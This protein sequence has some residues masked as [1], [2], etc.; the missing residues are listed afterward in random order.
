MPGLPGVA[1]AAS[2]FSDS[3]TWLL[4]E[5]PL[6]A[7]AETVRATWLVTTQ[8][9]HWSWSPTVVD[10]N[11]LKPALDSADRASLNF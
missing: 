3:K 6:F 7:G 9:G 1:N 11:G 2:Q 5:P 8:F 4:L 10:T